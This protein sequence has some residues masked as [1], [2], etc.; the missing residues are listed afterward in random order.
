MPCIHCIN[1]CVVQNHIITCRTATAITYA[2][3]GTCTYAC[4]NPCM[5]PQTRISTIKDAHR[6]TCTYDCRSA[7]M[8]VNTESTGVHGIM[9]PY[10]FTICMRM[11]R[12]TSTGDST[13]KTVVRRKK[14]YVWQ[15]Q[16]VWTHKGYMYGHS[17]EG[18]EWDHLCWYPTAGLLE[19][20]ETVAIILFF[21]TL[22]IVFFPPSKVKYLHVY[23]LD[24]KVNSTDQNVQFYMVCAKKTPFSR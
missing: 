20:D 23:L 11:H 18:M 21:K 24:K 6:I 5:D 13:S 19:T 3:R 8:E 14:K 10:I 12:L 4:R 16:E 1:W 7:C 17:R 15:V 22:L 9:C 2:C